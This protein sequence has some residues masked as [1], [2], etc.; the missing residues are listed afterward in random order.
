MRRKRGRPKGTSKGTSR[1]VILTKLHRK[2]LNDIKQLKSEINSMFK[3]A[4]SMM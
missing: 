4:R 3:K 1:K 2:A